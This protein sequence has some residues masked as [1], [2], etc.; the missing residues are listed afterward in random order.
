[1][2]PNKKLLA[3]GDWDNKVCL[4]SVVDGKLLRTLKNPIGC[5]LVGGLAFSSLGDMLAYGDDDGILE[6]YEI[7]DD[8]LLMNP[9]VRI[10][11]M[12]SIYSISWHPSIL[13]KSV[14]FIT[15]H[16][17][18]SIHCW[19]ITNLDKKPARLE[20]VWNS[21]QVTLNVKN[22]I[23]NESIGLSLLNKKLLRQRGAIYNE[24]DLEQLPTPELSVCF[25]FGSNVVA[26]AV[27]VSNTS[28]EKLQ[29]N[30]M[31]EQSTI[32]AKL[33]ETTCLP[34][35]IGKQ[36][37]IDVSINYVDP[38]LNEQIKLQQEIVDCLI[39]Q[40]FNNIMKDLK[41]GIISKQE[42][43]M[44]IE[45]VASIYLGI[46]LA[47]SIDGIAEQV[48]RDDSLK[49]CLLVLVKLS[50]TAL[51]EVENIDIV[52]SKSITIL[53]AARVVFTNMDLSKTQI[54]GANLSYGIF[55][56]T[57]F[58]GADLRGVNFQGSWLNNAKFKGS[59]MHNVELGEWACLKSSYPIK[60]C[61]YV[62]NYLA[63]AT[64]DQ[65]ELYTADSYSKIKAF[66]G[67]VDYVLCT[68]FSSDGKWLA[69]GGK[70]K[71]LR[72]WQVGSGQEI[73]KFRKQYANYIYNVIFSHN[74]Q[75]LASSIGTEIYL[76]DLAN[77][78]KPKHVFRDHIGLIYSLAFSLNSSYLLSGSK[79]K[80]L[81]L[82]D[83]QRLKVKKIFTYYNAAIKIVAFSPNELLIVFATEDG[84]IH[85]LNR[86]TFKPA[87]TLPRHASP[88]C[89]IFNHTNWR[90][91]AVGYKE[92]I[93][94]LW[95]IDS[96]QLLAIL[97]GHIDSVGSLAFSING[98]QLASGSE[99]RTLRFWNIDNILK[100]KTN[101]HENI[102]DIGCM[103][104]SISSKQVISNS[105]NISLVWDLYSGKFIRTM[106][107]KD[108]KATKNR[109]YSPHKQQFIDCRDNEICLVDK[110][111]L[112]PKRI[113]KGHTN[114][115]SSV[116]FAP[117]N[118]QL[119][120]GSLDRTIR[121]W[122]YHSGKNIV[123]LNV[124]HIIT[125]IVW[126]ITEQGIFLASGGRKGVICCWQ[127][128]SGTA[129]PLQLL[130]SNR[131]VILN[132]MR[133]N[134]LNAQ[135]LSLNNAALLKQRG[136]IGEPLK[137]IN[138]EENSA[139]HI[140]AA[141]SNLI[142]VQNLLRS[143]TININQP[144]VHGETPLFLGAYNGHVNIVKVLLEIR[145]KV[146]IPNNEGVTP[147]YISAQNGHV[148]TV[149]M[150]LE[151]KA[152]V[153]KKTN[154]GV[155]SLY[156]AVQNSDIRAVALL[157]REKADVNTP[158]KDGTTP[159]SIASQMGN[160]TIVK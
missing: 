30:T 141:N 117:D 51:G 25:P 69:S 120:S 153:N 83:I 88:Q 34:S 2:S 71:T 24:S 82:W 105:N 160:V 128:F 100:F 84:T 99:D 107:K 48:Q 60:A 139:L 53:N 13:R 66:S 158:I 154:D 59:L 121:I 41:I 17:D 132:A 148:M 130:W 147:L 138:N 108:T 102:D 72:L 131:Q 35:R 8:I 14:I 79:D 23:L 4:W 9:L 90:Q 20:L 104:I 21:K 68:A 149:K 103:E 16:A 110:T 136:A 144:N 97:E 38:M 18:G 122:D 5:G 95:D 32:V 91:L 155:T 29:Q 151:A 3:S 31:L 125:N 89:M 87:G 146:D 39:V 116:S 52:A 47:Q 150:L 113:F 46:L 22:S 70:D 10:V 80:T 73:K 135:G 1:F 37:T 85:L 126:A 61:C 64:A 62:E 63:V 145:A 101:L 40:N 109:I 119:C 6:V 26:D 111:S 12:S 77:Y 44:R 94:G 127:F 78:D 75:L 50:G 45:M 11:S 86:L 118:K 7:H 129:K 157:L 137:L 112:Q 96:M 36:K 28:C 156:I 114:K 143:N 93:I 49:W 43:E 15:G 98:K 67:H 133:A 19:K 65:I 92:S 159:L 123:S 152:E 56:G 142:A 76:I 58:E 55:D 57:N 42:I 81:R 115:I 106:H 33:E 27:G 74:C 54:P 134:L 124:N 140:A